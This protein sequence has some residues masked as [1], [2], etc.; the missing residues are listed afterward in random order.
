MMTTMMMIISLPDPL[1]PYAVPPLMCRASEDNSEPSQHL[2]NIHD[3]SR[4]QL[5]SGKRVPQPQQIG[6]LPTIPQASFQ[7]HQQQLL[8]G[9]P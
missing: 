7:V 1:C 9:V 6:P 4:P 8:Q 3:F 5:N 2:V